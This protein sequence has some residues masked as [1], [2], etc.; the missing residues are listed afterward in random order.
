MAVVSRFIGLAL[1]TA[2]ALGGCS[3]RA[4]PCGNG[5]IDPGEDCDGSNLD[6]ET[7][8]S[9]GFRSGDLACSDECTLDTTG[10][11]QDEFCDPACDAA[12]CESCFLGACASDCE[13]W[14]TCEAGTCTSDT[15]S[16]TL[17]FTSDEHGWIFGEWSN[18]HSEFYGGPAELM[19]Q[20]RQRGYDPAGGSSLLLS[21]GDMWTGPAIST[22]YRGQS[23]VEVMNA[24]GYSAAAIGNHEFDF[25]Q[26][27][28]LER[29][30]EADFPFL[31]ANLEDEASGAPPAYA[32]THVVEEVNGVQVGVV[33]LTLDGLPYVVCSDNLQGLVEKGYEQGLRDA[34]AAA[35]ADGAE[36]LVAITHVCPEDIMLLT[37]LA[38]ELG[39]SVLAGGHC[40]STYLDDRDG[41]VV[42]SPGWGNLQLGQVELLLDPVTLEVV[43]HQEAVIDNVYP[44]GGPQP[45][46]PDPAV[47]AIVDT[48]QAQV[49][50]EL[51]EIIGY[52]ATGVDDWP[53]YNMITDACLTAVP[54]AD[55]AIVNTTGIRSSYGPGDITVADTVEVQPFE[56]FLVVVEL[57]GAQFV[58]LAESLPWPQPIAGALV[59]KTGGQT[60]V[61]VGGGPINPATTYRL[62]TLDYLVCQPDYFP[63]DIPPQALT[64]T[65]VHWRQAT[66]DWIRARDSSGEDPLEDFLDSNPR[67]LD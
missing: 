29:S 12:A 47:Q 61:S 23:V 38:A 25:G 39:I 18:D 63:F 57:T 65:G 37:P 53:L 50:Q 7:C 10:C 54:D 9:Q 52:T 24:M 17:F 13:E 67:W 34:A 46:D 2:L 62:V 3:N 21:D 14:E 49:D 40:H 4:D 30:Q 45:P 48:W 22:W 8:L 6:D 44:A 42:L 36:V 58:E 64:G 59:D 32:Q 31:A 1:L 43:A 60:T 16:L 41:V 51:G 55:L 28:L 66:E 5:L 15:V 27:V 33:G 26:D 56:N 19:T 20:L 11:S 35:L